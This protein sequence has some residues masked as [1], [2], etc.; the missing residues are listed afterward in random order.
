[1]T[2]GDPLTGSLGPSASLVEDDT[3]GCL[4]LVAGYAK[5]ELIARV[6]AEVKRR[7]TMSPAL[8]DFLQL[9]YLDLGPQPGLVGTA[10]PGAPDRGDLRLRRIRPGATTSRSSSSPNRP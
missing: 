9:R 10:P 3:E 5:D 4:C 7:V 6:T 1:M 2:A 8:G